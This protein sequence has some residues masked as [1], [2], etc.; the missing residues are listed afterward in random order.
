MRR[1]YI[2]ECID[3]QR[4]KRQCTGA[5]SQQRQRNDQQAI[6]KGESNQ[7]FDHCGVKIRVEFRPSLIGAA[8]NLDRDRLQRGSTGNDD[9][10]VARNL[11]ADH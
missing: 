11:A 7:S 3:R 2:R 4:V 5:G 6:A 8:T 10:V 1:R 9:R